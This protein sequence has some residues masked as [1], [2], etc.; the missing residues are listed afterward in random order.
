MSA[1]TP[2]D[3][4]H[5]AKL[6]RLGI[7]EEEVELFSKQLGETL[8]YM[9]ILNEVDTADVEET[10]QVTG[11]E[12][13]TKPDEVQTDWFKKEGLLETSPLPIENKQIVVKKVFKD[14]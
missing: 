3:V 9:E 4:V 12:H 7:T 14:E 10:F 13:A 8:Q 11:I 2:E 6:A 1:I 5:I